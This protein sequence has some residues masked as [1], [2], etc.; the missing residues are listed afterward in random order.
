VQSGSSIV[1]EDIN[2]DEREDDQ[3]VE[4]DEFAVELIYGKKN[5]CYYSLKD[6]NPNTLKNYAITHS[7]RDQVSPAAVVL[8]YAWYKSKKSDNSSIWGVANKVLA[9]LEDQ[10]TTAPQVINTYLQQKL[11][12]NTLGNDSQEFIERMAVIE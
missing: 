9:N 4:A 5:A 2:P 10:E 12:W 7:S 8:N 3:E 11:D 1:D 6:L